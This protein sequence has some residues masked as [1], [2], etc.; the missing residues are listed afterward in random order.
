MNENF[1]APATGSPQTQHFSSCVATTL[2]H[3]VHRELAMPY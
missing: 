1:F 3:S 2:L